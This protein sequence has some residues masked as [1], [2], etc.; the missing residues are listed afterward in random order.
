MAKPQVFL[1]GPLFNEMELARNLELA[2]WLRANKIPVFLPQEDAGLSYNEMTDATD[3]ATR[4]LIFE[5]DIEAIQDSAVFLILLD[6]RVPD[7][8]ACVELGVAWANKRVCVGYK[9]D[10]RAL[11]VN[12]D[13]NIMIDFALSQTYSTREELL[14]GLQRMFQSL[15]S[16]ER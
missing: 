2:E 3:Q 14:A 1:A 9:T 13:N 7:E 5:R 12:G 8:G 10:F 11:D 4:K 6:G 16:N 15:R